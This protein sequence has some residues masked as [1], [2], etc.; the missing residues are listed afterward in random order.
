MKKIIGLTFVWILFL[1]SFLPPGLAREDSLTS[2]LSPFYGKSFK[3]TQD[4]EFISY[5]QLLRDHLVQK[6]QRDF[7]IKLDPKTYSGFDLLEIR[8]LFKCKKGDEPFDLF[9]K[10]FPRYP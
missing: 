6:I 8:S 9:L 3:G 4:P 1:V 10:M 2:Q 5:D 7:G